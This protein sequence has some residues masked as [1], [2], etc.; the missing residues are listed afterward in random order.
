MPATSASGSDAGVFCNQCGWQNPSQSRFCSQC[1]TAL[2]QGARAA[3]PAAPVP[4]LPGGPR[5]QSAQG[6]APLGKRL[7][8]VLAAAVL[9]VV[10]LF[11]ITAMSRQAAPPTVNPPPP[12]P[13]VSTQAET[14]TPLSPE[15]E[16]AIASL[17]KTLAE[18]QGADRLTRQQ[19]MVNLLIGY[20]RPDLAAQAQEDLAKLQPSAP[21]WTRAGDLYF[22]W[23][24]L[25]EDREG[26]PQPVA[27]RALAAYDSALARD[28][29]NLDV[30]ARLAWAAQYDSTQPMRA[31]E[32]T[33]AV[34]EQ[35][36]THIGALQNYAIFLARIGRTD[37]AVAQMEKVKRAAAGDSVIVRSANAFIRAMQQGPETAP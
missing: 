37:Q 31:I 36:S 25:L 10:A 32:E 9:L 8:V 18:A 33:K 13:D 24:T 20:G 4:V 5:A 23:L 34:L 12:P 14:F 2:Q 17:E 26:D 16:A 7:G 1:G 30:R 15:Q 29:A 3:T 27:R 6:D 21:A 35:D 28:A 19:E 11:V 22:Q